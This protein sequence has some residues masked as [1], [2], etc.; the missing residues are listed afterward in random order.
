MIMVKL[1]LKISLV[2]L[3]VTLMSGMVL[4]QPFE[5]WDQFQRG[6]SFCVDSGR[7]VKDDKF[8]TSSYALIANT[9]R[10]KNLIILSIEEN[11][12]VVLPD[13][14]KCAVTVRIDWRDEMNNPYSEFKT[15][16]VNFNR[17]QL[18]HDTLISFYEFSGGHIIGDT[19]TAIT[20]E[21]FSSSPLPDIFVLTNRLEIERDYVFECNNG[22]VSIDTAYVSSEDELSVSWSTSGI[23]SGVPSENEFDFEWT[24]YDDSS[25][26]IR[27]WSA[28]TAVHPYRESAFK[29]NATRV[30][31]SNY[32]YQIPLLYEEG[33]LMFRIRPVK[34]LPTGQRVTGE[35]TTT[36]DEG[37][38]QFIYHLSGHEDSINWQVATTF[39]EEGKRKSVINYFDG[40]SKGRQTVTKINTDSMAVVAETIY[41]FEGRPVVSTLPSPAFEKQIKH[42]DL[43]NKNLGDSSYSWR[44][45]DSIG[46]CAPGSR[47]MKNTSGSSRYYSFN[48]PRSALSFDQYIPNS[49][50]YPFSETQY[51]NDL[52]NRIRR[53]AGPG[54]DHH[55]GTS[56]E[57]VTQYY[58]GAP[59]QTELDRLFASEVGNRE[60][61]F[62]NA[63][64]DPNGQ[65][66]VTYTDMHGRTI[67]T[68]LAG[69]TVDSKQQRISDYKDAVLLRDAV[70][71]SNNNFK[72]G[73][74]IKGTKTFLVTSASLHKF[75]YTLFPESM[76]IVTCDSDSFCFDC[77][78][79]LTI[80]V[81]DDCNGHKLPGDTSFIHVLRNYTIDSNSVYRFDTLCANEALPIIDS[82]DLFLPIGEYTVSK[83][84]SIQDEAIEYY[85]D[86][87]FR[88]DTCIK[89][90]ED[91]YSDALS[92]IDFSGC[93]M[94]CA[95]CL[96]QLGDSASFVDS[97]L[98][99]ILLQDSLIVLTASDT[100]NAATAFI[101]LKNV[102]DLMC[103]SFNV[104]D[105]KLE[106]LL[107][108]M[109][110]T[111]GQYA[112]YIIDSATQQYFCGD[113]TS[114]FSPAVIFIPACQYLLPYIK[115]LTLF[116]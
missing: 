47:V 25:E 91:F 75:Y 12:T 74:S 6:V 76:R 15:L 87:Y 49:F 51:T 88:N 24:F 92:Q 57:R 18:N 78:Y 72:E 68:A 23:S 44:D 80:R 27:G 58:Y 112:E 98:H 37:S 102:C 55:M 2:F 81:T 46:G 29:W 3:L 19:I 111:G 43:Y 4:A 106:L 9:Y 96:A 114:I 100:A 39:A 54:K 42:F 83:E 17:T 28:G 62:K 38:S 70:I 35:W 95:T 21:G 11:D 40:S 107:H 10:V 63:V 53:S 115:T 1:K 86:Y 85:F 71:D 97:F 64:L 7:S 34:V 48:N 110:P 45:L 41:D 32:H 5:K 104:C 30:V 14:F 108:D 16:H 69:D 94:T 26:I 82:F 101:E 56:P 103:D 20:T 116:I 79:D 105:Q 8:S 90:F 61:Y 52:T 22:V 67:A 59:E 33:Y 84:L 50:G 36:T 13:S 99:K 66:S 77:V 109:S 73:H 113:P 93:N 60:H 89:K 31:T 65:V